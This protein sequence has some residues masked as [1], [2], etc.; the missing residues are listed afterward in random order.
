VEGESRRFNHSLVFAV[1]LLTD[2]CFVESLAFVEELRNILCINFQQMIFVEIF[3]TLKGK[4]REASS[5][6]Q[7]S[8]VWRA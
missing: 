6:I 3:D 4:G 1:E 5:I 2:G 8:G 7:P